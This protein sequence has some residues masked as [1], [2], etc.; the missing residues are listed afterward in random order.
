MSDG[1]ERSLTLQRPQYYPKSRAQAPKDDGYMFRVVFES[2]LN[3]WHA[4]LF[5]YVP[6]ILGGRCPSD[7]G[8]PVSLY[9]RRYIILPYI[10]EPLYMFG[11]DAGIT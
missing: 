7:S 5:S 1:D 9:P 2:R 8:G 4:C 10:T 3:K 6:N 11:V